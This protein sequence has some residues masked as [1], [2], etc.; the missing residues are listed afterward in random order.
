MVISLLEMRN[1]LETVMDNFEIV[2]IEVD[3]E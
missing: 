2:W 3:N 1:D